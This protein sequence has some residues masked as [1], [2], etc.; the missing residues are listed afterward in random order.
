MSFKLKTYNNPELNHLQILVDKFQVS[1]HKD[2]RCYE[3]EISEDIEKQ[4]LS[5]I[6][7]RAIENKTKLHILFDERGNESIPCGLLALNF[8]VVGDFSTLSID[9]IFISKDYR[10]KEILE[11]DSKISFYLLNVAL[12]EAKKMNDVSPIDA[13]LLTPI[14]KC[15]AKVYQEFGF[16]E[17][18]EDWLYLSLDN[19]INN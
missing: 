6:L 16:E 11:L 19:T 17:L 14:N 13:V 15:V 8:E 18:S 4:L 7:Q 3:A 5:N 10:G 2:S 9:L 12:Q 1:E